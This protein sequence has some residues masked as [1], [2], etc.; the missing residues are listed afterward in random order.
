MR[1]NKSMVLAAVMVFVPCMASA[2]ALVTE[3]G[4]SLNA[5]MEMATA[6]KG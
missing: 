3:R 1:T 4:I 6:K 2:Q 5:A